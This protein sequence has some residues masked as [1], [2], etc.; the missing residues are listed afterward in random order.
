MTF[1]DVLVIVLASTAG[2]IDVKTRKIPNWLTF[3]AAAAGLV[4]SLFVYG[5]AGA[6]FSVKGMLAGICVFLVPFILG[7]MG[8]GD[9]KLMGAIGALKGVNFTLQTAL[10]GA[11]WGGIMALFAI[12]Y[13]K[14]K[15]GNLKSLAAGLKLFLFTRGRVGKESIFEVDNPDKQERIYIP[16]GLAIFLGVITSYLVH[17]D[18]RI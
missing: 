10:F 1:F 14:K 4:G 3:T 16:Y 17:L 11:L 6:L 5:W 2:F 13:K 9:V 8:G 7:G 12:F 18:I 15:E